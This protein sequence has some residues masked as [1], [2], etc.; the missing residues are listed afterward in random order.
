MEKP[1]EVFDRRHEWQALNDFVTS[2]R[3]GAT[4]GLVYGRRRQG[5]TFLLETLAAAAGGFYFSALQQSSAQNLERLADQYQSFTGSRAR[6]R[7]DS[8]EQGL[9]A[10]L[11]LG[12]GRDGPVPVILD[13]FPY[14]LDGAPELPSLL[15]AILS[16]RGDAVSHWRT[17]LILCGSALST[18]RNLLTGTAPLRGR[19]SL[20]LVLHP[21]EY[22]DAAGFWQATGDLQLATQL[23]A[24]VGGTPAYLD[25][26][27]GA[28]PESAADLPAWVARALL[29]PASAMFREGNVLLA[30]EPGVAGTA[31]YLAV[32]A[33]IS[34]GRTR[35]GEIAN[36]LGRPEGA[37]AHPLTVLTHA[38]LISPLRDAVRQRR[39]TFHIA[40]PMLRLHTLVIAPHESRLVRHQ[41]AA[42]WSELADTVSSKIYGPH[43]EQLS[44]EWCTLHASKATLGDVASRVEPTQVACREHRSSHEV[45]IVVQN[46]TAN[47][48]DRVVAIGEAKWQTRPCGHDQLARLD[49]LRELMLLGPETRLL[50][51]SRSGFS[52][53]LTTAAGLRLDVELVDLNRLYR[54]A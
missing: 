22:R 19:A 27:S 35:R 1:P 21:F 25:M 6:A 10:L 30:S 12:E 29:N 40:E 28:G 18:M 46:V 15:Q 7:F 23:H 17:R 52:D 44:R 51:F 9:L 31:G 16:P 14:L 8:W 24:L 45:D 54:G 47:R 48:T 42:V 53:A 38:G 33:A 3:P 11:A 36:A 4:L 2:A 37:I 13:E 43:F 39:T 34:Q 41:G 49:H 5:K 50:L 20:E 26:S 32:L